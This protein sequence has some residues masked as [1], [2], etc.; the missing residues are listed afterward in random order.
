MSCHIRQRSQCGAGPGRL[1]RQHQRGGEAC[2][3]AS[4]GRPGK[5]P[6][7]SLVAA[8]R[9]VSQRLSS[10]LPPSAHT[11]PCRLPGS[12]MVHPTTCRPS[13][14]GLIKIAAA[15]TSMRFGCAPQPQTNG[16]SSPPRSAPAQRQSRPHPASAALRASS[17]R[18]PRHHR[19]AFVTL[20]YLW[21]NEPNH[22]SNR[23]VCVADAG[24]A[25]TASSHCLRRCP[26]RTSG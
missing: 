1:H 6:P 7:H 23:G 13:A 25:R 8:E 9:P 18:R 20:L 10:L 15:C 26:F 11:R 3:T 22:T 19:P 4:G 12:L 2:L 14:S 5:P 24:H 21:R 16:T 17:C